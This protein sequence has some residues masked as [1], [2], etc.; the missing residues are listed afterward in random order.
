M[1]CNCA[2]LLLFVD[3]LLQLWEV[4]LEALLDMLDRLKSIFGLEL[5]VL[6]DGCLLIVDKLRNLFADLLSI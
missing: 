6:L 1:R 5:N 4:T 3:E 2:L